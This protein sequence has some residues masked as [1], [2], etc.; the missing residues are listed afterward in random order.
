[1]LTSVPLA[2]QSFDISSNN[3][4]LVQTCA[5]NFYDSGGETGNYGDNENYLTTFQSVYDRF[6]FRFTSFNVLS[7]DTLYVYD[8]PTASD[9]VIG[10]YSG[11]DAPAT[12][13]STNGYITFQFI[14]DSGENDGGWE[15]EIL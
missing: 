1:M 7:G 2:A 12:V 14:S 10:R 11:T 6:M 15:S 13:I 8:G 3:N 4:D 9:P 5:G